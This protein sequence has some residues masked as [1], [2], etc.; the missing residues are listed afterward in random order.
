MPLEIGVGF[1]WYSLDGL[2]PNAGDWVDGST[3]I[4]AGP[5][6]GPTTIFINDLYSFM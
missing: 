3:F 5:V 6:S 4:V 2:W 1:C